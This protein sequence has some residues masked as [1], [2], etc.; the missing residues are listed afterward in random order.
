MIISQYDKINIIGY[1]GFARELAKE[2]TH[3][4]RE[5]LYTSEGS[6]IG[7]LNMTNSYINRVNIEHY[8]EKEYHD[9]KNFLKILNGMNFLYEGTYHF[10]GIGDC[11]TRERLYKE[12]IELYIGDTKNKHRNYHIHDN[13]LYDQYEDNQIG[14]GSMM[15]RGS[16]ITTN[17]KLGLCTLMNLN[18]TVGHD[19]V[20]GDFCTL[21]PGANVAGN[22]KIGDRVYIGMGANIIEGV[23]I[24]SDVTIGAGA[25]VIND[26]T[27][28][29]T[30]VGVPAKPVI[31]KK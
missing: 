30:Y 27:E 20:I 8:V 22:V 31:I 5:I 23:T 28:S 19:S 2:I 17:V 12:Y 1:G 26:I 24:C 25:V 3:S 7:Y 10:I 29:G 15:M 18:T 9:E 14:Y 13:M 11:K 6:S 16:V 4:H 21:S